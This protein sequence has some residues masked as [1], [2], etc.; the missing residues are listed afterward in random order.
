V[1]TI[2]VNL[3]E[4]GGPKYQ[5]DPN[6]VNEFTPMAHNATDSGRKRITDIPPEATMTTESTK[7]GVAS[8]IA[9]GEPTDYTELTVSRSYNIRTDVE[10]PRAMRAFYKNPLLGTGYS[11]ITD[12]TDNDFLRSL[13]EVGILGS[14]ALA[15]IFFLLIF[16]FIKAMKRG[17]T[18]EKLFLIGAICATINIL[19]TAVFIDVLEASKIACLLW[20]MLGV[21]WAVATG[22][23]NK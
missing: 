1:A 18:F 19:I 9:E 13:G 12:A 15:L 20:I 6:V 16:S 23:K 14:V 8:D 7:T 4:G 21:S 17:T 3:L 2:T 22:Y 5:A 10:W 11:S